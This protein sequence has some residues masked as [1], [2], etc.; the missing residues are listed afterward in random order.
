M[1]PD[2]LIGA[3]GS[4]CVSSM[5]LT[6]YCLLNKLT[7]FTSYSHFFQRFGQIVCH[8][9]GL[10]LL[11]NQPRHVAL[12]VLVDAIPAEIARHHEIAEGCVC[13]VA[14]RAHTKDNIRD[15]AV[16]RIENGHWSPGKIVHADNSWLEQDPAGA[17][18]VVRRV[19]AAD[20]AGPLV[21]VAK[22]GK[23]ALGYPK[24]FHNGSDTFVA[25]GSPKH[26]ETA[27]L[28]KKN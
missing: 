4:T 14:Y 18:M 22:G 1:V 25:W 2:T 17:R 8:P 24:L 10:G 11:G 19:T 5:A 27:S 3:P 23:V 6:Q 15:I 16:T 28:A 12:E 26:V 7:T 21:E 13:V 20:V 9:D